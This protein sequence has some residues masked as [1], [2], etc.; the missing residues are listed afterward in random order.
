MTAEIRRETAQIIHQIW[1][2]G[3]YDKATLAALCSSNSILSRN[4]IAVWPLLLSN[5]KKEELSQD[6]RP[7]YAERAV[8]SALRCYAI[9][10]QGKNSDHLVYA[11]AGKT[12][13]GQEL[14]A[15]LSGL[16]KTTDTQ[17]A[18]DRRV[19]T[20]LGNSNPESVINT[21][22]HLV[23]ILKSKSPQAVID[24]ARLAQDLYYFQLNSELARQ[25]CLKWGQQ[26]Y[27]VAKNEKINEEN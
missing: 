17:K 2:D 15:A 1:S 8:Y 11:P 14:F 10:Q 6:G 9:Y 16:R 24:F 21:I 27:Y 18:L 3:A 5:M 22:Y 23:A 4:A 20:V 19:Q 25:I 26:Y 13:D 12:G 7:T